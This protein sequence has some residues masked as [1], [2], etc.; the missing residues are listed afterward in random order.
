M[1]M[2]V[3][4][5]ELVALNGR[6]RNAGPIIQRE[7]GRAARES[8]F[9]IQKNAMQEVP[10]KIGNLKASIGPPEVTV[11]G[12]GA[13][14]KISTHADYAMPVHEGSGR[15]VIK[16]RDKRALWWPGAAHPVKSVNHPGNKPNRFMVRAAQRALQSMP[17]IWGAAQ[18][19]AAQA[20]L[21]GR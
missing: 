6:T 12:M 2:H 11:V 10:V 13:T 4:I 1:D 3:D 8:G 20:I 14:V 19:R 5:H 15:H 9:V 21:G 16:P 17:R 18:A 7:I